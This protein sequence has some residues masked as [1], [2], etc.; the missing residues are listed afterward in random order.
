MIEDFFQFFKREEFELYKLKTSMFDLMPGETQTWIIKC[1][2]YDHSET[3]SM[4]T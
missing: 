2:I 4:I 3:K 1:V